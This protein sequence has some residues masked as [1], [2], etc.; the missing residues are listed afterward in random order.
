MN[1]RLKNRYSNYD[2][3][4]ESIW[5]VAYISLF[6]SLLAFF[7]LSTTIIELEGSSVRRNYQQ[8]QH[9]LYL[10]VMAYKQRMNVMVKYFRKEFKLLSLKF[11]YVSQGFGNSAPS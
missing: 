4:R 9:A 2:A 8:F 7:I 10:Q 11:P 1:A 3:E 6:T 5:L